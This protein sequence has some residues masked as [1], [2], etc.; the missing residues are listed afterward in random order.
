MKHHSKNGVELKVDMEC[1][2]K[3]AGGTEW[4]AKVVGLNGKRV[5]IERATDHGKPRI[6]YVSTTELFVRKDH[7]V[8]RSP[9]ATRT[10]VEYEQDG[11]A[12]VDQLGHWLVDQCD[13]G[14]WFPANSRSCAFAEISFRGTVFTVS[15]RERVNP[16]TETSAAKD[17]HAE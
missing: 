12:T 5:K 7:K 17:L 6:M 10:S 2:Y 13:E 8:D 11:R 16:Y 9:R 14:E 15:V 4:L 3:T 1:W